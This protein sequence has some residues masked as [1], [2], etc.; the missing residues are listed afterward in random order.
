MQDYFIAIKP[1]P[2]E[3]VDLFSDHLRR[4][5][6]ASALPAQVDTIGRG[7]MITVD[8]PPTRAELVEHAR[9]AGDQAFNDV[10]LI[11]IVGVYR[12]D[13]LSSFTS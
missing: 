2:R 11:R 9:E 13:Q 7:V 6:T 10:D 12:L 1:G 5:V 8:E 4:N 3:A